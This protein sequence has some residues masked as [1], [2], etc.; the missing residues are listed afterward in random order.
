M[1]VKDGRKV[2]FPR[3]RTTDRK[4]IKMVVAGTRD[5]GDYPFLERKLDEIIARDYRDAGITIISGH[6]R[7]PD[8][9]GEE[10]ARS[11]GYGLMVMPAEWEKYGRS[12]AGKKRNR[13]MAQIGDVLVAFWDGCSAGTGHMI[14]MAER[15]GMAAFVIHYLSH[16][17]RS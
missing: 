10:Y 3:A 15:Y 7:G 8:K 13:E 11:R 12:V 5:F 9:F 6:A 14:R 16:D 17:D 1:P 4:E 2:E